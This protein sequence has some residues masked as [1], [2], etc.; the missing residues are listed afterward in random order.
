[1]LEV[2]YKGNIAV[3]DVRER[4]LK[5]EHPRF[6]IINFVKEAKKGTIIEVHLPH[7]AQPLVKGL[8]E[9]GINAVLNE[10][11]PNHYRLMCVKL[12]D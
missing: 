8:E 4:I 1:M 10:L 7:R 6:E 5:G 3:I 12:D 9:I 11:S 2:Q